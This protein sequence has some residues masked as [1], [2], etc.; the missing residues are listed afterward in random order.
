[1]PPF[2]S[3][4]FVWVRLH[5]PIQ[6]DAQRPL[7]I[8]I[9]Q[10]RAFSAYEVFVNGVLVGRLGSISP[11]NRT[12]SMVRPM[13]FDLPRGW[14]FRGTDAVVALRFWYSP[15][16]R[17]SARFDVA[18]VEIDESRMLHMREEAESLSVLLA[19]LPAMALNLFSLLLGMVVL[20]LWR[21]YGGRDLL[22]CG[23]VLLLGPPLLLLLDEIV[24]IIPEPLSRPAYAAIA[25]PI[26][27]ISMTMVVVFTWGLNRLKDVWLK[28][29]AFASIAVEGL[30]TFVSSFASEPS[31]IAAWAVPVFFF[32][33]RCYDTVMIAANLWVIFV[34]RQNRLI[35]ATMI[36]VPL[37]SLLT[38]FFVRWVTSFAGVNLFSIANLTTTAGLSVALGLR[39]WKEWRSRDAL[40][41]EFEAAREVQQRLVAPAPDVPGFQVESAY[42]P[43][44]RV[45][46]DFFYIRPENPDGLLVVVGDVSGKG[47]RAAL[48]VSAIMG[49]LRTMP[50]LPPARILGALNQGLAG[51]LRGGFVT[52]C[53]TRIESGG[54]T[55]LANA[56]HLA[57]YRN[58]EELNVAA[59]LPLGID[60]GI[61]YDE[62]Q[63]SLD[64]AEPLTF[65][66]D[67]VVE[68]RKPAG[69]LFG[70]E[71]TRQISQSSAA[72]I[73]EAAKAFGQ[74]DDITVVQVRRVS[75]DSGRLN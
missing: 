16:V 27:A 3:D 71:R 7:A 69:E 36:L 10:P 13:I 54:K 28:R 42:L 46:G 11:A 33:L 1:M 50:P 62:C 23:G 38:S 49:A 4:G 18:S 67:G 64:Q 24:A 30:S 26:T 17:V 65:L 15:G 34:K 9:G 63:L 20:F 47:L 8:R 12:P 14:T 29:L 5:L 19:N 44:T 58:G 6:S 32:T 2:K 60:A 43:A 45:G 75:G 40:Q 53:A 66:S 52:C 72:S 41:A 59:G 56:G 31:V 73:A 21:G 70:F 55:T 35:A 22:L 61:Q 51:Q 74:E 25:L 48:T 39:A 68:A 37:A 57:P